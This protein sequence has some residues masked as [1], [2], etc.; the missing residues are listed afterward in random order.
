MV[1]RIADCWF[2]RIW[3]NVVNTINVHFHVS[4]FPEFCL[5]QVKF[6]HVSGHQLRSHSH[7]QLGGRVTIKDVFYVWT[8]H[9]VGKAVIVCAFM[10]YGVS[11]NFYSNKYTICN[12][13]IRKLNIKIVCTHGSAQIRHLMGTQDLK[14]I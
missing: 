6:W 10:Q 13:S 12:F 14:N 1:L 8:Y 7:S 3:Y 2:G 5:T 4:L 11:N 9:P